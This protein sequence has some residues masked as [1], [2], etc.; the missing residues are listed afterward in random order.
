MSFYI[1][2]SPIIIEMTSTDPNIKL[3]LGDII[4]ITA[5]SNTQLHNTEFLITYIDNGIHSRDLIS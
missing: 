3:E 1:K 5:P 2:I 4:N